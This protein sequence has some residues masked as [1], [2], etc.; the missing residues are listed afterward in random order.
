[1]RRGKVILDSN[2]T[3]RIDTK[4]QDVRKPHSSLQQ[5]SLK[6]PRSNLSSSSPIK[7]AAADQL[8]SS[9]PSRPIWPYIVNTHMK[10]I[11]QIS[12]SS[13]PS[14][15]SVRVKRYPFQRSN[16]SAIDDYHLEHTNISYENL[17][18]RER[19]SSPQFRQVLLTHQG[20][21]SDHSPSPNYLDS[22]CSSY[23]SL[24]RDST[25][26][27]YRDGTRR[28]P[29]SGKFNLKKWKSS[30]LS[31]DS[32]S[33]KDYESQKEIEC[34]KDF[35]ILWKHKSDTN[36]GSDPNLYLKYENKVNST[37]C[38]S[39][40]KTYYSDSCC[41]DDDAVKNKSTVKK[42]IKNVPKLNQSNSEQT[43]SRSR[44]TVRTKTPLPEN[45]SQKQLSDGFSSKYGEKLVPPKSSFGHS[46]PNLPIVEKNLLSPT[47]PNVKKESDSKPPLVRHKSLDDKLH[48]WDSSML[49]PPNPPDPPDR[50]GRKKGLLCRIRSISSKSKKPKQSSEFGPGSFLFKQYLSCPKIL[51]F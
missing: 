29:C 5:D 45:E 14:P 13:P 37:S 38:S 25:P 26:E 48:V 31:S 1:M 34:K 46:H 51:Y 28:R 7:K 47:T 43:R 40:S 15:Q 27:G 3:H 24:S 30:S 2:I 12:A 41:S 23:D 20:S 16:A 8:S 18:K 35:N 17:D 6:I 50:P 11:K 10:S 22:S 32:E 19:V 21:S 9:L 4:N 42:P 44:Y 39:Y 33:K 49:P 36:N